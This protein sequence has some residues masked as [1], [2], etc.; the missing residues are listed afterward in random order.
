MKSGTSFVRFAIV[1]AAFFSFSGCD[2]VNNLIDSI[3]DGAACEQ[4]GNCLG[5]RCL[6]SSDGFPEGYCTTVD[7]ELNGCSNIFGSECLQVLEDIGPAC[8]ETC[9]GDR[10]CRDGYAC[11]TVETNNVCLPTDLANRFP[12]Q[13]EIG[14]SCANNAQCDSGSCLTNFVG[15]YCTVLD[16]TNDSECTNSNG[17]RC[18][19]IEEGEGRNACFRGC[20]NDTD[21]RFGYACVDP[22]G[23]GGVCVESDEDNPV[24]NPNGADDGEPCQV[25][26]NCKGGTCLREVEGYPGGYCTTLDCSQV[27]CNAPAGEVAECVSIT[28]DTACFLGCAD[29]SACREGYECIDAASGE[30]YCAPPR[31]TT[32]PTDPATG[33]DLDI[34]CDSGSIAGGRSLTFSLSD[35][36]VAFSVVPY[37]SSDQIRPQRLIL[38]DGSTGANFSGD[39]DFMSINEEILVN[40]TPVFFPAAPQFDDVLDLG[41]GTYTLEV[42]TA[43]DDPCFYVLEKTRLGTAIDLN[44]YLVGVPGVNA[45]NAE[46]NSDFS[47]ML[48]VFERIY[49]NADIELRTVRYFDVTGAD[50]DRFRVIRSFNDVYALV[51]SSSDPGPSLEERISVNVFLI[52]GFAVPEAPG[53]LGLSMGIPGVPGFHGNSGAGLVFTSEYLPD[54]P[55]MIGQTLAHEIGHF[56]GLRHTTEHPFNGVVDHDP[57][58]DTPECSDPNRGTSCPDA[59]NFMFPFSLGDTQQEGVT[60]GQTYVLQHAPFTQ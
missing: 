31:G 41:G 46:N 20:S 17:G 39:Y 23:G 51:A 43:D 5:G 38:P 57:I 6:T 56:N 26:I 54:D 29:D 4:D 37:S 32:T 27:G 48:R 9:D 16:C 11:L 47:A 35:D 15:G 49:A 52:E 45:G 28:N 42:G 53:L 55:E 50:L 10:P 19:A 8:Y 18:L 21:C 25:D 13:G 33:G 22:D 59:S 12:N 14:T 24:R 40:I 2:I 58:S 30:G 7:C 44:F 36:A 34:V 3:S 60:D 1:A